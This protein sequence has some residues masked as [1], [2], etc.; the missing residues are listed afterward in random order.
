MV[1]FS[2]LTKMYLFN[3]IQGFFILFL[4]KNHI[5]NDPLRKSHVDESVFVNGCVQ[6]T[7]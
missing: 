1:F 3:N 2:N 5:K 6:K 7:N 4:K